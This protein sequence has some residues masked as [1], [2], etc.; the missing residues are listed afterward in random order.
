MLQRTVY[1]LL[2]V[3]S[4]CQLYRSFNSLLGDLRIESLIL[5]TNYGFSL[6]IVSLDFL[7][8]PK[9]LKVRYMS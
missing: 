2:R 7:Q 5:P 8:E 3:R 6:I 1:N 4:S 9:D